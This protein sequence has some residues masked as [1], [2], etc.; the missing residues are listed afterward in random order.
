M[1]TI[2]LLTFLAFVALVAGAWHDGVFSSLPHVAPALS[3][4]VCGL[5]VVVL[6]L[7]PSLIVCHWRCE[8]R[9][10]AERR[11]QERLDRDRDPQWWEERQAH[12]ARV[13]QFS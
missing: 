1:S 10:A 7:L 13:M 9:R 5:T 8:Q 2:L 4:I 6:G 3:L 12:R 11:V